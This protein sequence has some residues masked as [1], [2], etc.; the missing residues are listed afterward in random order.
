MSQ[1]L[2][3][4]VR[5]DRFPKSTVDVFALVIQNDGGM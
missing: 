3:V 2:E 1:A 5:L 4:A